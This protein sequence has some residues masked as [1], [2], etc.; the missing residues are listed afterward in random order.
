M[1]NWLTVCH[2]RGT[3][4]TEP[5]QLNMSGD[6]LISKISWQADSSTE[7]AITVQV[8]T[9]QLQ[10]QDWSDWYI[11]TNGA[12]L[13]FERTSLMSSRSELMFRI[14]FESQDY[15]T[16]PVFHQLQLYLEPVLVFNNK[17]DLA[18]RPEVWITKQS[19]GNLTLLNMNNGNKPFSFQNLIDQ[20]H[21]YVH[22]E[23]EEIQTSLPNT[24]RYTNFNNEYLVLPAGRNV[25]R[26]QGSA[27]LQFR[28]QFT[29]LH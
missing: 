6:D 8:R 11:C 1:S 15:R 14:L 2:L 18:C 26:V 20:E 7:D 16:S 25:L 12:P 5:I 3:Y 10:Q 9:R 28:Y 4:I 23:R 29:R 24:Y 22:N 17:G 19:N 13:P 27:K 21:L